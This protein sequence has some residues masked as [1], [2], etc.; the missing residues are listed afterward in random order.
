[1]ELFRYEIRR[2]RWLRAEKQLLRKFSVSLSTLSFR[3]DFRNGEPRIFHRR[4]F[5]RHWNRWGET[6]V[7]TNTLRDTLVTI[8]ERTAGRRIRISLLTTQRFLRYFVVR[9]PRNANSIQDLEDMANREISLARETPGDFVLYAQWNFRHPFLVACLPS[10]IHEEL[11]G[12]RRQYPFASFVLIPAVQN[13][14][15]L[16]ARSVKGDEDYWLVVDTD[17]TSTALAVSKQQISAV[18]QLQLPARSTDNNS[19]LRAEIQ[20]AAI[21]HRTDV[22]SRAII[23][24]PDFAIASGF[25]INLI[26]FAPKSEISTA[27]PPL[28]RSSV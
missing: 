5:T 23:A 2:L 11:R 1:M 25:R 8:A 9:P 13:A 19:Q 15:D 16:Y 10:V 7:P 26:D 14:F 6:Q 27:V 18:V 28:N 20:R 22:P 3:V 21:V 17:Q 4:P 12:I 24:E